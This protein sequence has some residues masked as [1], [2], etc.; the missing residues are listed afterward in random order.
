M[1]RPLFGLCLLALSLSACSATLP[2]ESPEKDG[3]HAA[4]TDTSG[5]AIWNGPRLLLR[6]RGGVNPDS[7]LVASLS[8]ESGIPL[9]LRFAVSPN[10]YAFESREPVSDVVFARAL[11]RLRQHPAI[12]YV[13]P[14][15]TVRLP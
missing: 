7:S 13:E 3:G 1:N 6:L 11:Q 9:R 14:D 12:I 5:H 15:R 4:A 8:R 2:M 10:L